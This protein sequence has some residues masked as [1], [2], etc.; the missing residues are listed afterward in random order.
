VFLEK[1]K[2]ELEV[3]DLGK[4][5]L[6][7]AELD[8]LIGSRDL[9]RT[10]PGPESGGPKPRVGAPKSQRNPN[11]C[12]VR[13]DWLKAGSAIAAAIVSTK[14][15]FCRRKFIVH[16]LRPCGSEIGMVRP[17]QADPLTRVVFL[18][19]VGADRFRQLVSTRR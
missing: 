5:R 2:A 10:G 8:Q 7:I 1:K 14:R 9:L 3:R 18:R 4:E 16:S 17:G 15:K 12:G 13:R 11:R 19:V 6:S